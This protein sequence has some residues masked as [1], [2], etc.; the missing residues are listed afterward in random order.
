[1]SLHHCWA[2]NVGS[3]NFDAVDR[4]EE[5]VEW[6]EALE[7]G[8]TFALR[9]MWR[10]LGG[11]PDW[12]STARSVIHDLALH[13]LITCAQHDRAGRCRL[14]LAAPRLIL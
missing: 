6:I 12:Y 8:E 5:A 2:C 14:W 9:I 4:Y 7:P 11:G 3:R 1:M 10:A 13:G